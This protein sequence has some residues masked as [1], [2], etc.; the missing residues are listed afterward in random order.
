RVGVRAAEAH[1]AGEVGGN[2]PGGV[3]GR[4]GD[5]QRIA[6]GDACRAADVELGHG[7]EKSALFQRFQAKAY[8]RPTALQPAPRRPGLGTWRIP[9]RVVSH[10]RPIAWGL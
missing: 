6:L 9:R 3:E 5:V 2:V 10:R 1:A 7:G 4:H 8:T